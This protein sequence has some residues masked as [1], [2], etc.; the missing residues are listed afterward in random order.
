MIIQFFGARSIPA[1]WSG[2]DT[3]ATELALRFV[4]MGHQVIVY[5]MP[6]YALPER[7]KHYKGIELRYLQ[8]LYGK[9][10]ETMFHE[11]ISSIRGF[12]QKSDINYI[13]GCRT[14]WAYFPYKIFRKKIVFN[15]D[16]LD[17]ARKK[18]GSIAK[19]FLKFGYWVAAKS[20]KYLIHDNTFIQ[21]YFLSNYNRKGVF[22]SIGGYEYHSVKPELLTKYNVKP[23]DYYLIA[24][25]FE[26]ENNID[27]LI[28]GFIKSNSQK[29]LLIA[30]GANYKS[31]YELELRSINNSRVVF[32]G[33]IYDPYHIEELHYNCFAYLHG[34][35]VGGTNPSLL[36]A[37]GCGNIILANSTDFNIEVLGK[38]NGVFF[39]NNPDDI[40]EKINY[41][42][43]NYS[44]LVNKK[45]SIINRLNK[46]YN[47]DN[48]AQL[49][50]MYFEYINGQ[51]NNYKE[52]F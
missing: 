52:T 9:N 34:H 3:T 2:F 13:L 12:F 25:R 17:F 1:R 8:T 49:H 43:D 45:K 47:W 27:N 44:S 32:L 10:T 50:I 18:W 42:E 39:K 22:I 4:N 36:K 40:S 31:K 26:P 41:I 35:E 28:K 24:C 33:P 23:S 51:R 30:G 6:K 11:I 5:V 15:T 20:T 37:M 21:K 7:P 38:E 48:S 19:L 46:Y 16:G 14:S 29:L